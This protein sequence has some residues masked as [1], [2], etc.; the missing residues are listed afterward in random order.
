MRIL[1]LSALLVG[2]LTACGEEA[3]YTP[4]PDAEL[5]EQVSA[6]PGVERHHL[7]ATDGFPRGTAYVGTVVVGDEADPVEVLDAVL[8]VLW[9]GMPEAGYPLVEVVQ[10]LRGT[11][12]GDVGLVS[13]ADFE[14][15]YGPQPGSGEPPADKPPLTREP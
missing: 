13:R 14:A 1:V 7:R 10:G 15:R 11:S 9:Q 4:V 3:G 12:P 6:L 8:A 2:L 5:Y